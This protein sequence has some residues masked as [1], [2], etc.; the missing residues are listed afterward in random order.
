MLTPEKDTDGNLD[1]PVPTRAF[2]ADGDI[3]QLEVLLPSAL[4]ENAARHWDGQPVLLAGRA[5][6]FPNAVGAEQHTVQIY[7]L[8]N[9]A[10]GALA[11]FVDLRP[12]L[13]AADRCEHLAKALLAH[14]TDGRSFVWD[15]HPY[16]QVTSA[17]LQVPATPG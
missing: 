11:P 10:D 13:S 3:L 6:W 9:P 8:G 1:K 5:S 16:V 4:V 17:V 12:S 7:L 15:G 14:Y 2:S